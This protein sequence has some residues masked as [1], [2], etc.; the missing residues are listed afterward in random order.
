MDLNA[1]DADSS[2]STPKRYSYSLG[3]SDRSPSIVYSDDSEERR[4]APTPPRRRTERLGDEDLAMLRRGRQRYRHTNSPPIRLVRHGAQDRDRSRSPVAVQARSDRVDRGG[5]DDHGNRSARKPS[6]LVVP[7]SATVEHATPNAG[8]SLYVRYLPS[9][10][11]N[12]AL[13][14]LF[15]Q[16]GVVRVQRIDSSSCNEG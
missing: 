4:P 8:N 13:E 16:F 9:N 12:Q 10:V 3:G 2:P 5:Y 14:A 15:S 6:G 7:Q 11:D 1:D